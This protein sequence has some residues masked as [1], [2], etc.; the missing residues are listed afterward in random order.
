M[1]ATSEIEMWSAVYS[2]LRE[3]AA[4]IT[5][6][7]SDDGKA[8]VRDLNNLPT[9]FPMPYIALGAHMYTPLRTFGRDGQNIVFSLDIWGAYQ[10]RLEVLQLHN[11]VYEAFKDVGNF[12][13][14]RYRCIGG[15][16][17]EQGQLQ[18]DDSTGVLLMRYIDTYRTKT[19]E[20]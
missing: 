4:L 15:I 19:E 16:N 7:P 6:I 8:R 12:V 13:M 10:G 5:A 1:M 9:A 3:N 14:D 17:P 18:P 11:L 20:V 2:L